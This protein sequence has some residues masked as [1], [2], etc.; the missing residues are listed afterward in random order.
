MW[1]EKQP[2]PQP[3]SLINQEREKITQSTEKAAA[4]PL[5]NVV[6]KKT[7]VGILQS[8]RAL[9]QKLLVDSSQH[10]WMV[11]TGSEFPLC[12]GGGRGQVRWC[13]VRPGGKSSLMEA[14]SLPAG[15]PNLQRLT[16]ESREEGKKAL[17]ANNKCSRHH[18]PPSPIT[19]SCFVHA[20]HKQ[21]ATM[22]LNCFPKCW[23]P[24]L[25]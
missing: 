16:R 13:T 8:V 9:V 25:A 15:I 7:Y 6:Q 18:L 20:Q 14:G 23:I 12:S 19:C 24:P 1:V 22:K 2:L 3:A 4:L 5:G 17:L 10:N 21:D 11:S